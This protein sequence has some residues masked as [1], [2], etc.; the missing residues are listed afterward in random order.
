MMLGLLLARA[1]IN[2]VVLEKHGDFLRDFRGDTV[3][4]STL[5]ILDELGLSTRFHELP[6]QKVTRARAIQGGRTMRTADFSTLKVRYPYV[7]MVPQWDFLDL[8]ATEASRSPHFQL[9][10]NAEAYDVLRADGRIV[11]V[12]YH[13]RDGD[14][15]LTAALTVAADGRHST[16][17]AAVGLSPRDF[18]APMDVVWFR[19]SRGDAGT[20][21]ERGRGTER[22]VREAREGS[23]EDDA[24]AMR[25]GPGYAI[26]VIP[27]PTHWQVAYLIRK[28]GYDELRATGIQAFRDR[29]AR[30]A[31]FLADRVT[32][33]TSFDDARF[34]QV[35]V[36]RLRR[37]HLP[38]LLFIGDAAHAMSPV[39]GVGINLAIQDAVAAANL[40]AG[41][42]LRTQ[43]TGVPLPEAVLAAVQRRRGLPTAAT[44]LFQRAIS[45]VVIRR[46]LSAAPAG[47]EET[48]GAAGVQAP[49]AGA[50]TGPAPFPP[51]WLLRL[52]AGWFARLIGIGLRPEHVQIRTPPEPDR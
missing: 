18:G 5:E 31:P 37:W 48:E 51:E 26:V 44:Q 46:T 28:G 36:D 11:G 25:L 16:L 33:L 49:A 21:M 2:V 12:R 9:R 22:E 8:L 52:V 13:D 1:G 38:G 50:P 32:E 17:R 19:L 45:R 10:M 40:L 29:L 4:P 7:A 15:D 24:L 42:L 35:R 23:G 41:P 14:H 3:H 30:V 39:G 20:A 43:R 27:R 47:G 34:L 6:H